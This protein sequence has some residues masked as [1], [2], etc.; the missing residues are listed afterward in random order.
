MHSLN[1]VHE[2][3]ASDSTGELLEILMKASMNIMPLEASLHL[4]I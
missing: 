2:M 3:N 1:S 4:Y